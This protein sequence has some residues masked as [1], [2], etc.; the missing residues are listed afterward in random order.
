MGFHLA[1][2]VVYRT[3]ALH[4]CGEVALTER[5]VGGR[6]E[7]AARPRDAES[8]TDDAARE[9]LDA[10]L[11]DEPSVFGSA[12]ADG[13]GGGLRERLTQ[14]DS[15]IDTTVAWLRA[16]AV[17]RDTELRWAS[18]Q[19]TDYDYELDVRVAMTDAAGLLT[20]L[21]RHRSDLR[22]RGQLRAEKRAEEDAG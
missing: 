19:S 5:A 14:L 8:I 7:L 4:G 22:A 12:P 16:A 6:W 13:S 11:A 17:G 3:T 10:D 1:H 18:Y 2:G 20:Q 15:M 21:L 9:L